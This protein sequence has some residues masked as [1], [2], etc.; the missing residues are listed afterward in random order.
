MDLA[1]SLI[2]LAGSVICHQ[3]PERSFFLTNGVQLPVCARCTG[4]Y[5]GGLLAALGWVGH[6]VRIRGRAWSLDPRAALRLTVI[7][8]LPTLVSVLLSSAGV[9]DGT[10][11]LRAALA[12]PAG[13][14]G[15]VVVAAAATKDL[16]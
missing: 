11:V 7:A 8:S 15:G 12:L 1:V 13:I 9:W 14:A 5:L 4:L 3:L 16:R 2:Y 6:K 10:N